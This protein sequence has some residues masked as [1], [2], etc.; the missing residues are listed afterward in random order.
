M[1]VLPLLFFSLLYK[2]SLFSQDTSFITVKAGQHITDVFTTADIF[3]YPQFTYGKVF[4][5]DGNTAE[6]KMNYN[7]LLDEMHFIDPKGDTLA[8]ANEKTIKFITLGKDSFYHNEGYLRRVSGNNVGKLAVKQVWRFADKKKA[9]A[10]NITSSVSSISSRSSYY[11]G[12]RFHNLAVKEDI[13]LSKVEQYYIGDKYNRF[14]LAGK[15]NLLMLFPK[16][17]NRIDMY[18]KENKVH[19]SNKEDLEK[20]VQFLEHL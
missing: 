11:D 3:Y 18:L 19:F 15:K 7:R 1:K 5:K 17:Q 8:L 13:V 12:R 4:F 16:E 14:V 2:I 20:I 9:S 10:Y 6:A